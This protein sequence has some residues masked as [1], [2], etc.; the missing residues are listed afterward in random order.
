MAMKILFAAAIFLGGWLWFYLF[1]RQFLF[2]ILTAYPLINKLK[3]ASPD[4][5]AIGATR[6]TNISIA[7]CLVIS[8]II[9]AVVIV[10]CPLYLLISFFVGALLGFVTHIG[11]LTP[12]NRNMFDT[13]CNGYYRFVPDDELRTAMFNKKPG[14]IKQRLYN[15][16][17]P[18][19]F[20][21]DFKDKEKD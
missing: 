17:L 11:K 18:R 4:L 12:D 10:F 16:N 3:T 13:F 14:Q 8:A 6:Y 5:I 21:P 20:V 19:D 1:L 9:I 2:N 7:V 15:M